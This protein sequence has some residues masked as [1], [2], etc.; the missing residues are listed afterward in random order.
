MF[1]QTIEWHRSVED[2]VDIIKYSLLFRKY[3]EPNKWIAFEP[4][5]KNSDPNSGILEKVN[6]AVPKSVIKWYKRLEFWLDFIWKMKGF[7][8]ELF[9]RALIGHDLIDKSYIDQ[10][11]LSDVTRVVTSYQAGL[12]GMS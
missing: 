1:L 10:E 3:E 8:G 6:T 11:A 2:G 9:P 7:L 5:W 4:I 12:L